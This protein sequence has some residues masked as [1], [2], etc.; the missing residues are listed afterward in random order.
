M[1]FAVQC[2]QIYA[3]LKLTRALCKKD[4]EYEWRVSDVCMFERNCE[5]YRN[6]K[7]N[8]HS[9]HLSREMCTVQ[10][11]SEKITRG[12]GCCQSTLFLWVKKA[13][14]Q[15][16]FSLIVKKTKQ[17]KVRKMKSSQCPVWQHVRCNVLLLI[18]IA[19]IHIIAYPCSFPCFP[20]DGS[21]F[22]LRLN[23]TR[24]IK[25]RIYPECDS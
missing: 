20:F 19:N 2:T 8:K 25:Y 16:V 10:V 18:E 23:W 15:S 17:K 21:R 14:L 12:V 22:T 3:R 6:K 7:W 13:L 4:V 24:F 5:V 1:W 9:R 11:D